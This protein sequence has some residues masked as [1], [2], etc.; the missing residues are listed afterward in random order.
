VAFPIRRF[1]DPVLRERVPEVTEFDSSLERLVREM[2]ESMEEAGGVGLAANQIGVA[3][4]V[5][6][7][8]TPEAEGVAVNPVILEAS[9]ELVAEEGCLSVPGLWFPVRRFAEVTLAAQDL[10]GEPFQVRATGLLARVFQHE[11]DHLEGILFID[12]LEG[13]ERRAALRRVR[14]GAITPSSGAP[15]RG[16]P[17]GR[18]AEVRRPRGRSG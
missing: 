12:R 18:R 7:Y 4:R 9:G 1:G 5:F 14:E 3:R 6:V 11:V 13:E 8:R 17:P 15:G 16:A 10:R 2:V